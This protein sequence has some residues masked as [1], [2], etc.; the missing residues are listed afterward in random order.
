MDPSESPTAVMSPLKIGSMDLCAA[1]SASAAMRRRLA[2]SRKK[3]NIRVDDEHEK[4]TLQSE[5]KRRISSVSVRKAGR[6]GQRPGR[7]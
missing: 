3:N 1:D 4:R 5:R 6:S 2:S 7:A